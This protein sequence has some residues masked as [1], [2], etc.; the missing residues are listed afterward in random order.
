MAE[1]QL[2]G[3]KKGSSLCFIFVSSLR[4]AGKSWCYFYPETVYCLLHNQCLWQSTEACPQRPTL[5]SLLHAQ[6]HMPR[7]CIWVLLSPR[8]T[9][10]MAVMLLDYQNWAMLTYLDVQ[11]IVW[12]ILMFTSFFFFFFLPVTLALII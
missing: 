9:L 1:A 3:G 11:V 8:G 5:F 4:S 6:T 7:A 2:L 10:H 12:G